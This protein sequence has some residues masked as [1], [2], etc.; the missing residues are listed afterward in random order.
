LLTLRYE[1][2]N[3]ELLGYSDTDY[4]SDTLDRKSTMGYVFILCGAAITWV[5]RKQQKISTLTTEVEYV[6]LYNAAK[7]A[8]WIHNF[9]RDIRRG[10]YVGRTHTTYILGDN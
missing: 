9:L 5:S 4:A 10:E 2:D 1:R 6:G 8:V 3:K 7:E